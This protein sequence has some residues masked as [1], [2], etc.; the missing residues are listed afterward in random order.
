MYAK[1][2][3]LMLNRVS[4]FTD[5]RQ[6]VLVKHCLLCNFPAAPPSLLL[7]PHCDT[8]KRIVENPHMKI[9]IFVNIYKSIMTQ[10]IKTGD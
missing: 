2:L 4:G 10:M 8:S 6:R 7:Q 9:V 5:V 3:W 1:I